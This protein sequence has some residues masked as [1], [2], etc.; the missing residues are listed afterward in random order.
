MSACDFRS[1]SRANHVC[2]L[3]EADSKRNLLGMP[4]AQ[5][6]GRMMPGAAYAAPHSTE[7]DGHLHFV[8]PVA[9]PKRALRFFFTVAWPQHGCRNL[10]ALICWD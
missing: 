9:P 4:G 1:F 10:A 3:G 5:S 7:R 8:A 2:S 6:G